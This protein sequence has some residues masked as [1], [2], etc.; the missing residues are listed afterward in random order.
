MHTKRVYSGT[1]PMRTVWDH[2]CTSRIQRHLYSGSFW[3]ISSLVPR[4][5]FNTAIGGGSGNE[6]S[7]FPEGMA[8]CTHVCMCMCVVCVCVVVSVRGLLVAYW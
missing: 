7:V 5:P 8:M 4:P 6:T 3:C 1:P 2:C